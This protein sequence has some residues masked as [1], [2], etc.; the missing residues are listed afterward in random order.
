MPYRCPN[1]W[2]RHVSTVNLL[3]HVD[4]V[5]HKD[6]YSRCH[7]RHGQ[8]MTNARHTVAHVMTKRPPSWHAPPLNFTGSVA[9]FHPSSTN[10][11]LAKQFSWSRMHPALPPAHVP[12]LH[13]IGW[14]FTRCHS[15]YP[16]ISTLTVSCPSLVVVPSAFRPCTSHACFKRSLWSP[17]MRCSSTKSGESAGHFFANKK[18]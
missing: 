15:S 9:D 5:S 8:E 17:W 14:N 3:A 18:K 7:W 16:H 13:F 2:V 11:E 4:V 6:L 12:V 10:H 1:C